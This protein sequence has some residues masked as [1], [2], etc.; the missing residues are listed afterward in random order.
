LKLAIL[1]S[2]VGSVLM[3]LISAPYLPWGATDGPLAGAITATDGF[4]QL[5]LDSPEALQRYRFRASGVGALAT[6]GL[7]LALGPALAAARRRTRLACFGLVLGFLAVI[8]L[9]G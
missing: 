9:S 3:L 2:A 7:A 8:L 1:A 4:R 5:V 6:F